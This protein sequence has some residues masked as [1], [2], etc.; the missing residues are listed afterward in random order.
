MLCTGLVISEENI[1]QRSTNQ[2]QELAMAAMFANGSEQN[3][4]FYICFLQ[5]FSSFGQAVLEENKF[6]EHNQSETR[7]ACGSHVFNES[8]RTEQS[9]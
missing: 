7:I 2:K 5:S 6:L 8:G 1:Y 3:E 4:Q 9:L